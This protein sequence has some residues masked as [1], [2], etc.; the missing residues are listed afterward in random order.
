MKSLGNLLVDSAIILNLPAQNAA[1]VVSNLGERLIEGGYVK[2]S[3]V[4]AALI[5][6]KSMPTGLPLNGKYNAAIPHTDI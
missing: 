3:F 5:R 2:D 1:D 4:Q 6:E